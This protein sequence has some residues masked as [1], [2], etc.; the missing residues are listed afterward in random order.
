M[1]FLQRAL[2]VSGA[3][4]RGR[5]VTHATE[6]LDLPLVM[7]GKLTLD[8]QKGATSIPAHVATC[9]H[10]GYELILVPGR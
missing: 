7:L 2:L 5:P 8:F 4:Y 10:S 9:S 1:S 3:T 6:E